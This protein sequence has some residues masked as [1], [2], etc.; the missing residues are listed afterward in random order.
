MINWESCLVFFIVFLV[1]FFFVFVCYG[2][3]PFNISQINA[4]CME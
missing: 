2:I 1:D 3:F 4:L